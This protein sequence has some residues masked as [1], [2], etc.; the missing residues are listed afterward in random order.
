MTLTG[1]LLVGG[2][3]QRMGVDK[4]SLLIRGEPLWAR[5]LRLL[6]RLNPEA[7]CVSARRRPAWCPEDIELVLDAPPSR[8]P[9]SGLAAALQR[10]QTAHLIALAIDLPRVNLAFLRRLW[11]LARPGC[12]VIPFN[13]KYFEPLCAVY[14]VEAAPVAAAVL[15]CDDHSL[16]PLARRLIAEGRVQSYP[17]TPAARRLLAN[18]NTPEECERCGLDRI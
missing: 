15:D 7:L 13:G 6:R 17:L 10:R 11:R 18:A 1:V 5:Q 9:L 8:G 4:A 12:G 14:P 16:Q 3:S 2:R